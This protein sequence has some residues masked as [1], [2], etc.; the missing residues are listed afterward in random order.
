[1]NK[2]Q[3]IS[4]SATLLML[5][6]LFLALGTYYETDDEGL[7]KI[8]F[9][10]SAHLNEFYLLHHAFTK[11]I[12][13]LLYQV[14][15]Y[16]PW[17][18]ILNY[19]FLLIAIHK[20]S[21]ILYREVFLLAEHENKWRMLCIVIS[22]SLFYWHFISFNYLRL[23]ILLGAVSSWG[24]AG[25]YFSDKR[26]YR[27]LIYNAALFF[28]ALN[29]RLEGAWLGAIISMPALL[30]INSNAIKKFIK[31]CMA[32][33]ILTLPVLAFN[34]I[35]D[36]D[37]ANESFVKREK[38]IFSM[39][40]GQYANFSIPINTR[41][42]SIGIESIQRF[43]LVDQ[44]GVS[45]NF[46][47]AVFDRPVISWKN[48]SDTQRNSYKLLCAFYLT[49]TNGTLP[50]VLL[51]ML[52]LLFYKNRRF[53]L[54][55]AYAIYGVLL[56]SLI[57]WT[58]KPEPRMLEPGMHLL[59]FFLC[60]LFFKTVKPQQLNRA[61]FIS[62]FMITI[63]TGVG[64]LSHQEQYQSL[65][66]DSKERDQFIEN[67]RHNLSGK[68]VFIDNSYYHFALANPFCEYGPSITSEVI[69]TDIPYINVPAQLTSFCDPT[70]YFQFL[71]C[72][73]HIPN[74]VLVS[75]SGYVDFIKRYTQEV[76]NLKLT[77]TNIDSLIPNRFIKTDGEW[78]CNYYR[79]EKK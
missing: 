26:S 74:A 29:T 15:G 22:V 52:S 43:F 36:S 56:F 70:D 10:N 63:V 25:Y 58:L 39:F 48:F 13:I 2:K 33:V 9:H 46:L 45:F 47:D 16:I 28:W 57:S 75:D 51:I 66:A 7:Y 23:A 69:S 3:V 5:I 64:F 78:K 65:S 4:F 49:F 21:N 77:F 35:R 61:I 17:Y 67:L 44:K 20:T 8:A 73:Q 72:W 12:Y 76:Y 71:V 37:K 24:L 54:S 38:Y 55:A 18:D 53:G 68:T 32:L 14:N 79:L 50:F 42:D 60:I 34:Y 59:L 11:Y 6:M 30:I 31:P 62:I 19:F 41:I 27:V 40:E 1:M